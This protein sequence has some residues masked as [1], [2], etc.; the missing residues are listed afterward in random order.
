MQRERQV[1]GRWQGPLCPAPYHHVVSTCGYTDSEIK[2][3][4]TA[5]KALDAKVDTLNTKIDTN[6]AATNTK[7]KQL[8]EGVSALGKA[9]GNT[10]ESQARVALRI[11]DPAR[12]E[13]SSP[14]SGIRH[15]FIVQTPLAIKNS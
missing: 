12:P 10:F 15:T 14:V 5:V 6:Q 11:L 7:F 8:F 1:R 13:Y 4:L 2:Q 3:V 9:G